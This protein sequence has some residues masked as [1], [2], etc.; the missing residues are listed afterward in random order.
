MPSHTHDFWC[1]INE[2][3]LISVLSSAAIPKWLVCKLDLNLLFIV[4]DYD[5][6]RLKACTFDESIVIWESIAWWWIWELTFSFVLTNSCVMFCVVAWGQA[7]FW[8]GGIWWV[9][10][11]TNLSCLS[12]SYFVS[13]QVTL[14]RFYLFS[15]VLCSLG[16]RWLI[17]AIWRSYGSYPMYVRCFGMIVPWSRA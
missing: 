17:A 15:L 11:S 5:S 8:F 9:G 6:M 16:V 13:F 14:C 4:S 3:I 10:I 1:M 2:L 7:R 12:R